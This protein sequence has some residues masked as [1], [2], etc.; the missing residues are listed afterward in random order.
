MYS[1]EAN[2]EAC[3]LSGGIVGRWG[4][5]NG[6]EA[7]PLGGKT[8]YLAMRGDH[9]LQKWPTAEAPG[10]GVGGSR[11]DKRPGTAETA[12]TMSLI[13]QHVF[14]RISYPL[15]PPGAKIDTVHRTVAAD[16]GGQQ[17]EEDAANDLVTPSRRLETANGI[18]R[19]G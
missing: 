16:G 1:G 15:P 19:S 17:G 2:F 12:T 18:Q 7:T 6:T 8:A 10:P 9:P 11:V 13:T 3:A 4:R 14:L 5:S